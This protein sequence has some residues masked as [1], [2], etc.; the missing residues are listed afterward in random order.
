[1]SD[2]T[3]TTMPRPPVTIAAPVGL[4]RSATTVTDVTRPQTGH[5][6]SDRPTVMHVLHTLERAGAEVLVRDMV[7]AMDS[8]F[9]FVVVALDGRGPIGRE[10]RTRHVPVHVL[11]RRPGVDRL[12][13]AQ[14]QKLIRR[15]R[16]NI[17]HAHQYT[18]FFYAAT[19]R[20][21]GARYD[22]LIF[23]EHGRHW[24]DKR[25]WKRIVANRL[26]GRMVDRITAV[27][28]YSRRALIEY[29]DLPG[30][31]IQVIRNGID[32]APFMSVDRG[33]RRRIRSQ[34]GIAETDQVI[35][36]VGSLRPV[37]DHATSM[38][39]LRGLHDHDCRATLL[40]AGDGP[41]R[42][43]LAAQARR[44]G[45]LQH[46]RFLGVRDDVPALWQAADV[47]LCTSVSEGISVALLEAMA[48]SK[49]VVATDVGGNP[50]IVIPDQTGYLAPSGDVT[51][52]VGTLHDLLVSPQLRS[53]FG[54]A[55]HE[56][57]CEQF[58]Q[59]DMHCSY[60][61]LYGQLPAKEPVHA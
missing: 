25:R 3:T 30:D 29:E 4:R 22:G 42:N 43:E 33:A 45:V 38:K 57:V 5:A 53:Q 52:L 44:L 26:L 61:N 55:G 21:L 58:N 16:V 17:V 13:V 31:R 6:P 47:A 56:R 27:G 32:I 15:H 35:L 51:A 18:P 46:V 54:R 19:A 40:L 9:R 24:P 28:E 37:K 12:C 41:L 1:M 7:R 2:E 36:Q 34:L 11:H 60:A 10:L 23:T 14:L 39:A 48:A 8:D 49:A 59:I 50:E 20:L